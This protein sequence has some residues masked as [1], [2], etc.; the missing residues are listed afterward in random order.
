[1]ISIWTFVN[2][3][4]KRE[5]KFLQN[6][7]EIF[8]KSNNFQLFEKGIGKYHKL[9][10]FINI[11]TNK[12][13]YL[14]LNIS[15]AISKYCNIWCN[16]CPNKWNWSWYL[17]AGDLIDY[18]NKF[19][20]NSDY[21]FHINWTWDP[22]YNP[23]LKKIIKYIKDRNANITFFSGGKSLLYIDNDTFNFLTNAVDRFY[24]NLSASDSGI[25]NLVHSN[26]ITADDF[27]R[28][29]QRIKVISKKTMLIFVIMKENFDDILSF[30]K[31]AVKLGVKGIEF[32]KNQQFL[33]NDVL[34]DAGNL[35]KFKRLLSLFKKIKKV[36]ILNTIDPTLNYYIPD[37]FELK[38]QTVLDKMINDYIGLY[39]S[40]DKMLDRFVTTH[41]KCYQFWQSLEIN[42][43]GI[44]SL[45]CFSGISKIWDISLSYED[46]GKLY[47]KKYTEFKNWLPPM[48]KNCNMVIDNYKNYL[49]HEIIKNL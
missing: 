47:Q 41:N 8:H 48:C 20:I 38:S 26:W 19:F 43:D 45:C 25:Y 24:I 44:V 36:T 27:E 4:Y 46:N 39:K 11:V 21:T 22:I 5:I 18:L 12:L 49:K 37:D 14:P 29:L 32:K 31:L 40:L 33:K 16:F 15:L 9:Y 2:N 28:L 30:Y 1:M 7:K 6:L 3:K 23:D 17:R 34:N 42:E 10:D 35:L 13:V